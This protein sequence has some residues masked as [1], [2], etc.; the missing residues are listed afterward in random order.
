MDF[1]PDIVLILVILW[2]IVHSYMDYKQSKRIDKL[3]K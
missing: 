2:A 3:E 1:W